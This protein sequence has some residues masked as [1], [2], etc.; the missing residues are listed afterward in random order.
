MAEEDA[1][2]A[3]KEADGAGFK[4]DKEEDAAARGAQGPKDGDFTVARGDAVVDAHEDGDGGDHGDEGGEEEEDFGGAVE[5][6]VEESEAMTAAVADGGG[7]GAFVERR[8]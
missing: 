7:F 5:E 4:A 6:G 1:D 3:A 8:R 2:E